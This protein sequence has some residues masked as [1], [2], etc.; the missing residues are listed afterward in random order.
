M[1]SA[2][3]GAARAVCRVPGKLANDVG[4]S[5]GRADLGVAQDLL[6]DA[7]VH[8]LLQQHRRCGI[9]GAVDPCVSDARSL[10]EG[11]PLSIV[12]RVDRLA[13]PEGEQAVSAAMITLRMPRLP[14]PA[15]PAINACRCGTDRASQTERNGRAIAGCLARER[16]PSAESRGRSLAGFDAQQPVPFRRAL[17]SRRG[18]DLDLTGAPSDGQV[19]EPVVL[20]FAGSC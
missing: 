16:L 12:A 10:E 13:F 15:M 11:L 20:G 19:G 2:P 18:A 8:A 9:A 14:D 4:V 3:P 1:A 5:L 6:D 7:D 17:R